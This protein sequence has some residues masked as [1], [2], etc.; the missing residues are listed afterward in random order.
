MKKNKTDKKGRWKKHLTTV[1]LLI[2]LLLGLSLVFNE[3]IKSFLVGNTHPTINAALVDKNKNKKASF[4]FSEVKS[5]NTADVLKA[6]VNE[7][8]L[9][10]LG[11]LSIPDVSLNLPIAKGVSTNTLALAAGTLKEN[12]KMGE[13]NYALAGHHMINEGLLFS[14][15]VQMKLGQKIYLTDA[16]NIYEYT[17][18]KKKYI[19][20]TDVQVIDDTPGKTQVTLITCDDTGAGRLMVQGEYVQKWTY[21]AAPKT[22][23][24]GF[25]TVHNNS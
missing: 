13:G 23:K 22:V 9:V 11:E 20:A 3:Q 15:L 6:K 12:E 1:L 4:D 14:P 17:T 21:S 7:K 8:D 16:K 25:K 19:K 2:L 18:T 10:L 5:L 24:D